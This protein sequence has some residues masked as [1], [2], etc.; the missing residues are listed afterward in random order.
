MG[1]IAW[2]PSGFHR[3]LLLHCPE[4]RRKLAQRLDEYENAR[5][6]RSTVP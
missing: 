4:G 6:W 2:Q 1:R 5:S 3:E